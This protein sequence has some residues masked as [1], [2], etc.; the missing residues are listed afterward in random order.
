M[1]ASFEVPL[2][3]D[4]VVWDERGGCEVPVLRGD[5]ARWC[6][7]ALG[8]RPAV[9]WSAAERCAVARF[10]RAEDGRDFRERW[11]EAAG[12]EASVGSPEAPVA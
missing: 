6:D 1:T 8:E 5:A 4:L 10:A 7:A 3:D 12:R 2:P 11:L 9:A